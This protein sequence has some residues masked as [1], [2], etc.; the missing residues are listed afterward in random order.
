M[1]SYDS[2]I[3]ACIAS[4]FDAT[5]CKGESSLSWPETISQG[6][7]NTFFGVGAYK[8]LSGLDT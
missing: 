8:L 7:R 2:T 3:I 5:A 6:A 4:L 1:P